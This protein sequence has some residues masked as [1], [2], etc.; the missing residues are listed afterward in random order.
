MELT[1]VK[2]TMAASVHY[3]PF[4]PS[5]LPLLLAFYF[6]RPSQYAAE[7]SSWRSSPK[8]GRSCRGFLW[9]AEVGAQ[10]WKFLLIYFQGMYEV[11]QSCCLLFL[12]EYSSPSLLHPGLFKLSYTRKRLPDS[13]PLNAMFSAIESSL[14][15]AFH[16]C[17]SDMTAYPVECRIWTYSELQR[18]EI[19]SNTMRV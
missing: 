15:V 5:N 7:E 13:S 2:L 16:P 12:L 19:C 11:S 3:P 1:V 6:P 10:V 9:T 14:D 8:C 17:A 18:H 4:S